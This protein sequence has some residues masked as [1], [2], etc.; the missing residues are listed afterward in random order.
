[1]V[2]AVEKGHL[3]SKRSK[4]ALRTAVQ[5][6]MHRTFSRRKL[7]KNGEAAGPGPHHGR[8]NDWTG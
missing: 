4:A 6:V 5:K 8:R 1:M 7:G 2:A 3:P